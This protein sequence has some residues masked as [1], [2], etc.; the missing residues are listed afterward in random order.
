[1]LLGAISQDAFAGIAEET[2]NLTPAD[3]LTLV[4][5]S[6][7]GS[8]IDGLALHDL[9]AALPCRTEAEILGICASAATLVACACQK[10]TIS[11]SSLW[12]VHRS[13]IYARGNAAELRDAADLLGKIDDRMIAIYSERTGK[14]REEI[15]AAIEKDNY[16]SAAAAL[17]GGWV[18]AIAEEETDAVALEEKISAVRA[19]LEAAPESGISLSELVARVADLFRSEEAKA[20]RK[21]SVKLEELKAEHEKLTA[22]LAAAKAEAQAAIAALQ[23]KEESIIEREQK[24]VAAALKNIG[25][26]SDDLPDPV[27]PEPETPEAR[28]ARIL[29]AGRAGG[30]A[31]A[32]AAYGSK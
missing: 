20:E 28:N 4:I 8:A 24:A 7:G 15:T 10:I 22:E 29:E 17:A 18:D 6:D 30:L 12:M 26:A 21:A 3:T 1:M 19:K 32:L 23:E 2:K 31:A 13:W 16:M 9:I 5:N 27:E 25:A 11:A 14:S